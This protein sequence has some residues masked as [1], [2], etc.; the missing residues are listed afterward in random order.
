MQNRDIE[1]NE[2]GGVV[3]E[4]RLKFIAID[5]HVTLPVFLITFPNIQL[6][7]CHTEFDVVTFF[8]LTNC[9]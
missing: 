8:D 4:I 7:T 5:L 2:P 1:Y 3:E 9:V 6:I